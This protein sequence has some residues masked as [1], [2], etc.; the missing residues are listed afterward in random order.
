VVNDHDGRVRS[1]GWLLL[2]AAVLIVAMGAGA[3]GWA[4]W[5]ANEYESDFDRWASE[6]RPKVNGSAR[7]P[8]TAFGHSAPIGDQELKSQA[9]GCEE[10]RASRPALRAATGKMPRVTKLPVEWLSPAYG[11]AVDRDHRRARVV[12]TFSDEAGQVLR[13]MERDCAF[14]GKVLRLSARSDAQWAKANQLADPQTA[15]YCGVKDGCIP[16]D[17]VR[18][19]KFA[20]AWAKSVDHQH[21]VESL[22][23]ADECESTSFGTACEGVA[24]A[25]DRYLESED[26]YVRQV[27]A[28]TV[29]SSGF[30]VN[31]AVERSERAFK[32]YEKTLRRML[33]KQFPGVEKYGEFKDDP[34]SA[35]AFLSAMSNMRV[36]ELLDERTAMRNL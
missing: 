1:R 24:D 7:I 15:P 8:I 13:Q 30:A 4:T 5:T 2:G 3:F 20:S 22:Y 6:Q 25:I 10:I 35:D 14:E 33:T 23:R 18:R 34:T 9:G 19:R 27:R 28:L 21:A 16:V 29:S 26:E 32:K 31:Q 11:K 12:K 36:R 17:T